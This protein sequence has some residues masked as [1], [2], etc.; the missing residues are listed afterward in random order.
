M[1]IAARNRP[2]RRLLPRTVVVRRGLGLR[3]R[4]KANA[5]TSARREIFSD[6]KIVGDESASTSTN[7]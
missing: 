1:R 3:L 7:L 2:P 5:R 6:E 4:L